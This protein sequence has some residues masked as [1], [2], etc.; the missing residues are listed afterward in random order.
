[1]PALC[2]PDKSFE[3]NLEELPDCEAWCPGAK[4]IP[5]NET[6]LVIDPNHDNTDEYWEDREL[7]YL[8]EDSSLGVDASADNFKRYILEGINIV[9]SDILG[10]F[11]LYL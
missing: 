2:K 4:P 10:L 8:C 6:G 7:I 1:M 11:Y 9:R 3:V 5:P